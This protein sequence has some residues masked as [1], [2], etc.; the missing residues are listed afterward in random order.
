MNNP[1]YYSIIKYP[2][3]APLTFNDLL[4]SLH[5]KPGPPSKL[6][7]VKIPIYLATSWNLEMYIWATFQTWREIST[8][9]EDKR[10]MLWPSYWVPRPFVDFDDEIVRWYDYWLKGIDTEILEEPPIK[11]FVMGIN[12]WRFEDE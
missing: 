12:K 6:H 2:F 3:T 7:N 4:G 8:P 11:M 10:L 5:P 9:E 1:I